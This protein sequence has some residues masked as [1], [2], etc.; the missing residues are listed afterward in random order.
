MRN[1][2]RAL[3]EGVLWGLAGCLAVLE[4][5][6]AASWLRGTLYVMSAGAADNPYAAED[7]EIAG[8]CALYLL[9]LF[10]AAVACGIAFHRWKQK[11]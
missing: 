9:P 1:I 6:S 8:I 3:L 7:A 5:L 11:K 10:L 4:I 2:L